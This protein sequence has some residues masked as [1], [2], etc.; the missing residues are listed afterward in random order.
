MV[1]VHVG[2]A[3]LGLSSFHIFISE[4]HKERTSLHCKDVLDIVLNGESDVDIDFSASQET[5]TVSGTITAKKQ[6]IVNGV[7]SE[8]QMSVSF[9]GAGVNCQEFVLGGG[10]FATL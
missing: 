8:R 10:L 7:Q 5:K 9:C 4:C 3:Q 1:I 2:V 6:V